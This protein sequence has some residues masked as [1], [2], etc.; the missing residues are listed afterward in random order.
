MACSCDPTKCQDRQQGKDSLCT[1]EWAQ[2]SEGSFKLEYPTEGIPG[3]SFF[4][5]ICATPNSRI[6][7]EMCDVEQVLS[8]K[9]APVP[10]PP[11]DLPELKHVATECQENKAPEKKEKQT[12]AGNTRFFSGFSPIEQEAH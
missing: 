7:K 1:I 2:D 3:L 5:P 12:L 8:K 6:R 4:N 10:L 11:F 9:T